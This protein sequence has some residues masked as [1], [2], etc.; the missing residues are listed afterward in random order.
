[1]K[2]GPARSSGRKGKVHPDAYSPE[3]T[4]HH[5]KLACEQGWL[6]IDPRVYDQFVTMQIPL[7][8]AQVAI[9]TALDEIGA[10]DAKPPDEPL[11]PP[12]QGFVWHS[13]YFGCRMYLKVRLEGPRPRCKLYSLHEALHGGTAKDGRRLRAASKG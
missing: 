11:D 13:T 12:G 7:A 4:L 1:M 6:A 10:D 2:P 3:R 8:D 9:Q 5:A